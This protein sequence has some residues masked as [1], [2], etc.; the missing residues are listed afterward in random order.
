MIIIPNYL[1][2]RTFGGFLKRRSAAGLTTSINV[3]AMQDHAICNVTNFGFRGDTVEFWVS[4]T[5]NPFLL[6]TTNRHS[7][8][9][10]SPLEPF[11]R[12]RCDVGQPVS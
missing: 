2:T 3:P 8:A 6:T 4:S 12:R 5:S 1:S 9:C 7:S 10:I 11:I